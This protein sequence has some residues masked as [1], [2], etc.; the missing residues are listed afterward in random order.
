LEIEPVGLVAET[1]LASPGAPGGA[2]RSGGIVVRLNG[3][4]HRFTGDKEIVVGRLPSADVRTDNPT[5]S[6]EHLRIRP[7]GAGW[8]LESSGK[9]GTFMDGQ[10]VTRLSITGPISLT[11]GDPN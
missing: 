11:I 2:L 1:R 8:T 5:V 9:Q 7:E 6:R 10:A 3:Q 4:E